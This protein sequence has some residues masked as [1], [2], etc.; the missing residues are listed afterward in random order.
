M[1]NKETVRLLIEEV[2]NKG[3]FSVL[4]QVVHTNYH[5]QSPTET[6]DGI[7]DLKA[8]VQ[9]LRVAFPDLH[10]HILDQIAD[11]EKVCTRIF[12]TGTQ[13]GD[14][15]GLP[16]TGKAVQL[17]GVVISRLEAGLIAEE[18]ELLDQLT[19]LQQL[20]IVESV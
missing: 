1:N 8:F 4:D 14:F 11:E 20:G 5:Y 16:A 18:W 17:Q 3:N 2:L 12:M 13:Q 6:M 19:L 9:A 7:D 10:I 15:L